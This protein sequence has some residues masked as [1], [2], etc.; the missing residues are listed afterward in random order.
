M[1]INSKE[2]SDAGSKKSR[3][4]SKG[5]KRNHY[6]KIPLLTI[7]IIKIKIRQSIKQKHREAKAWA[8]GEEKNILSKV[9]DQIR[10]ETKYFEC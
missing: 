10:N 6:F 7:I 3:N 9:N 8:S 4:P 5:T 2:L 1:D